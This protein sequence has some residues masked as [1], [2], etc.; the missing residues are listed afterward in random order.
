MGYLTSSFHPGAK[1]PIF[2]LTLFLIED[3]NIDGRACALLLSCANLLTTVY[4]HCNM[5]RL[6]LVVTTPLFSMSSSVA[7]RKDLSNA[8]FVKNTYKR[9]NNPLSILIT[10]IKT[11]SLNRQNLAA[12]Q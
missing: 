7:G 1:Y 3:M 9:N 8:P 6:A 4:N 10:K 2:S 11:L 5:G 12:H